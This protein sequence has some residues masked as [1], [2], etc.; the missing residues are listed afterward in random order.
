M[1]KWMLLTLFLLGSKQAY[2]LSAESLQNWRDDIRYLQTQVKTRHLNAF[3]TQPEAD[4]DKH[5]E[6][7]LSELPA[8]SEVQVEVRLMSI[9]A[10]IGD[11]HTNYYPMS[12]PHQHFPFQ[13][14]YIDGTLKVVGASTQYQSL[15]GSEVV[16]IDGVSV[17]DIFARIKPYLYGVDNRYSRDERFAFQV[18]IAK[19][20]FAIGIINAP[21]K[22]TFVFDQAEQ[23][24]ILSISSVA[25][26]A[27]GAIKQTLPLQ[28]FRSKQHE[29]DM[30]GIQLAF[31]DQTKTAYFDFN[32]YPQFDDVMDSCKKLIKALAKRQTRHLIIDLRDNEGGSFYTGLAFS[33]CL[34]NLDTVDW[35]HGVVTLINGGTFSAA[36]SNAAQYRQVLNA[37]LIGSATGGDPNHYGE[38]LSFNL[39]NS[40]RRFSVSERYYA[41]V[42]AP[43]DALYP[44]IQI[45]PSW[46]DILDDRD[47]VL[48]KALNYLKET[49]PL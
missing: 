29:I 30:P 44:D 18:T 39:P 20:L 11:G 16:S 14:M 46:Q 31:Y 37:K 43:T 8:L 38:L 34:S 32:R 36:M 10:S 9:M 13:F 28:E 42:E 49:S 47:V 19:V 21:D 5:V 33:S 17:N 12:G 45:A 24:Q 27:F 7:L 1:S 25:M 4:F 48:D 3:H 2:G 35:Q 15:I 23:A 6:A 40:Q 41:F 26:K 22:A